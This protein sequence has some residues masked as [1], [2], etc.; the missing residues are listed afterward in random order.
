MTCFD[1][2][3]LGKYDANRGLV[4]AGMMY[5]WNTPS[6]K[7]VMLKGNLI[8]MLERAKEREIQQRE[9]LADVRDLLD[10]P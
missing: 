8:A 6:W 4:R 10:V 9:A 3:D 1:P 2:Q 7:L 5:S